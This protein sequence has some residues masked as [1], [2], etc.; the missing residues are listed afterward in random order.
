[1]KLTVKFNIALAGVLT[2]GLAV[3][4]WLSYG[5]LQRNAHREVIE[6]AG[7]MLEAA[8]A[9][10]QYTVDE[11]RPLLRAQNESEF[12]PQTVPAYAATQAFHTL[13]ERYPDHTY[14]EATLNP[15]NP[16][17]RAVDWEADLVLTFQNRPDLN[18][19]NGT[20]STPTGESIYLARPIRVTNEACLVCHGLPEDAPASMR[21]LYG[22]VNGFGWKLGD[23]VGAQV[24]SLPIS[25][26]LERARQTFRSHVTTNVG[27]FLVIALVMNVLFQWL[28][29]RPVVGMS[30]IA[31][32][33]SVGNI[34][35]PDFPVR[36]SD[37]IAELGASLTRLRRSLDE[38]FKMLRG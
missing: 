30:K 25:V 4:C 12:M 8:L 2:I 14:R 29:I 15:T 24:V 9:M 32:Q 11:V 7:L 35:A 5:E 18:E 21:K 1:M 13:R 27:V 17:N 3:T 38:A 23:V 26:P 37:E 19:V 6:R 16:N 36:G 34:Y 28:V 20:R 33:V 31:T 10:R 22:S